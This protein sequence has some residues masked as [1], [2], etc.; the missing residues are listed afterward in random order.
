MTHTE[1]ERIIVKHA[2]PHGIAPIRMFHNPLST[3]KRSPL[4][5]ARRQI[6][7]ELYLGGMPICKI[8]NLFR[9]SWDV[10]SHHLKKA[11]CG[12]KPRYGQKS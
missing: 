2:E 3:N 8:S 7:V 5:E 6:I 1:I 4:F 10:V 11:N 12:Y 9:L